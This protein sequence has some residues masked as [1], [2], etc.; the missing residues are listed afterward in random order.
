V[1]ASGV[2]R[3]ARGGAVTG[4][5]G[6]CGEGLMWGRPCRGCW[7][8]FF[9]APVPRHPCVGPLCSTLRAACRGGRW[10]ACAT[11]IAGP[12]PQHKLQHKLRPELKSEGGTGEALPCT[13]TCARLMRWPCIAAH[14]VANRQQPA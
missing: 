12:R 5:L 1:Q 10:Q 7:T 11:R 3:A 9:P 4:E 2:V 6:V 8:C 14:R 13:N